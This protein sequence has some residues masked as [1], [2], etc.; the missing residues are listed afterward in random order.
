LPFSF[1]EYCAYQLRSHPGGFRDVLAELPALR[2]PLLA[3]DEADALAVLRQVDSALAPFQSDID[4]AVR[5]YC[6]QGGFP[7]VWPLVDPL[8]K[9]EYLLENHVRKVLY[10]DLM[11]TTRYRKPENV[12]RFFVYLLSQ[13]GSEINT[14]QIASQAGVERRV[15]EENLPLLE[16]TDLV[17]RVRKF[18]HQ[19]IRV[20]SGNI[21]VYPVDLALRNAVLKQWEDFTANPTIMGLFAENLVAHELKR[22]PEALEVAYYREKNTEVDFVVTHGGNRHLPI[23]VKHRNTHDQ[24][25]G[26]RHFMKKYQ[27]NLGLVVTRE[28]TPK[29]ESDILW[30]PLRHFLLSN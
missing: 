14:A 9:M 20:R 19:P 18:S 7:E 1:R 30:I 3:G 29:Q 25:R 28:L 26:L 4:G 12:L 23:E 27:V 16:M 11:S 8:R 6:Q 5:T 22:W 13:P 15:V 2:D 21:K 24:V 17:V 10:E